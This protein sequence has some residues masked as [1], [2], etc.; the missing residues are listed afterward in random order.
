[1]TRLLAVVARSDY[2]ALAYLPNT[3]AE[4]FDQ[5]HWSCHGH[6]NG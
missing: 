3:E 5:Y 6:E 4:P 1:M 2:I